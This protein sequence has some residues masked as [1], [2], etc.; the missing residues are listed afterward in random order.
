MPNQ[1]AIADLFT[2]TPYLWKTPREGVER[3]KTLEKLELETS[4]DIHIYRKLY[5]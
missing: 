3:L 2:M 1:A 5:L 4:F